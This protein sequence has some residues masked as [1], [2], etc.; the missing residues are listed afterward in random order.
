MELANQALYNLTNNGST[1]LH[2]PASSVEPEDGIKII[3]VKTP[4][5][6]KQDMKCFHKKGRK[7]RRRGPKQKKTPF[8]GPRGWSV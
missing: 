5:N 4:R 8:D 1:H 6:W 7:H 3:T 2:Q